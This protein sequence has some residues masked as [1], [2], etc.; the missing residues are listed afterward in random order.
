MNKD[1]IYD[2]F[3]SLGEE[4]RLQKFGS[5]LPDETLLFL[6]IR[7]MIEDREMENR[8]NF[9]SRLGILQY[10]ICEEIKFCLYEAE[11][12]V[13]KIVDKEIENKIS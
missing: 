1:L 3:S 10:Q 5:T 12:S 4:K 8:K 7:K 9:I 2:L 6:E 11:R 13:S